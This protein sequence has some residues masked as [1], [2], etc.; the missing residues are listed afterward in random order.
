MDLAYCRALQQTALAGRRGLLEGV[1]GAA[2][3]SI[4]PPVFFTP[5]PA[6]ADEEVVGAVAEIVAPVVNTALNT[7]I[8]PVLAYQFQYPQADNTGKE[9][10]WFTSRTPER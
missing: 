2:A 9:L 6:F 4:L 10:K 5:A 3:L 8:E 7:M 1:V